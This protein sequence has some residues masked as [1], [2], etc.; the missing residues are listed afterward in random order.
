VLDGCALLGHTE[1]R[2]GTVPELSDHGVLVD[3][4]DAHHAICAARHRALSGFD[5]RGDHELPSLGQLAVMGLLP[6]ALANRGV[7]WRD[8][9]RW[10]AF[11]LALLSFS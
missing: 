5:L 1:R 11:L 2:G 4:L 8:A 10:L 7:G 6:D 9:E 3:L